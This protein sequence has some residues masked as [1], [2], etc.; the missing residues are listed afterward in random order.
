MAARVMTFFKDDWVKEPGLA[1][2]FVTGGI[3][4]IMPLLSPLHEILCH[5][6]QSHTLQCPSKM[7]GM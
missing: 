2:S 4:L 7:M 3:A 1:V 6:E 5:D